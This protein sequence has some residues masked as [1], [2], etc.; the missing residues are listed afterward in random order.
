[1]TDLDISSLSGAKLLRK[2]S[3]QKLHLNRDI[4]IRLIFIRISVLVCTDK[5]NII[6]Q[7]IILSIRLSFRLRFPGR[8]RQGC[9]VGIIIVFLRRKLL[10]LKL[11][12][13]RKLFLKLHSNLDFAFLKILGIKLCIRLRPCVNKQHLGILI[14]RRPVFTICGIFVNCDA[15][16]IALTDRANHLSVNGCLPIAVLFGVEFDKPCQHTAGLSAN[17][18]DRCLILLV[19]GQNSITVKM[20][21]DIII[22]LRNLISEI[23]YNMKSNMDFLIRCRCCLRYRCF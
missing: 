17:A 22:L 15:I 16:F 10:H 4:A 23:I 19:E 6:Q 11:N 1:M 8:F 21:L 3:A 7:S 5:R 18:A 12:P 13:I 14:Q 20:H 9:H 2:L